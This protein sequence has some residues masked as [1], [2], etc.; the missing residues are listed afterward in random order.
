MPARVSS[1]FLLLILLSAASATAADESLRLRALI[2]QAEDERD[3]D[4]AV[5]RETLEHPDP[6]MR[7]RALRALGRIGDARLASAV[8]RRLADPANVVRREAAFALGEIESPEAFDSL[9]RA[10]MTADPVLVGLAAEALAKIAWDDDAQRR[11]AGGRV[12]AALL[13]A[14]PASPGA[15]PE[16]RRRAL[17]T[18]WR[19]GSETPGLVEGLLELA[20]RPELLRVDESEAL[21]YC[22]SRLGDERLRELLKRAAGDPGT[23]FTRSHAARGL[24]ALAAADAREG[25]EPDLETRE[26]LIGLARLAEPLHS[27]SLED[28]GAEGLLVT[29]G[30]PSPAGVQVNALRALGAFPAPEDPEQALSPLRP[31]FSGTDPSVKLEAIALASRWSVA[32][33]RPFLEG[34]IT[35]TGQPDLQADALV[36]LAAIE[37]RAALPAVQ[38][39]AAS[40]DWRLRAAAAQAL[41]GELRLAADGPGGRVLDGLLLDEDA[42]VVAQAVSVAAGSG[43]RDAAVLVL[44]Q[45]DSRDPVVRALAAAGL[46]QLVGEPFGA[47]E[48]EAAMRAL[49]RV[50]DES[51]DDSARAAS[52]EIL[53]TLLGPDGRSALEAARDEGRLDAETVTPLVLRRTSRLVLTKQ[54]AA[55]ILRAVLEDAAGEV[56]ADARLVALDTLVE[57][58]GDEAAPDLAA[59]FRDPDFTVR[60]AAARLAGQL[61][62]KALART[63]TG[64]VRTGRSHE[65]YLDAARQER[66]GEPVG[67]HLVTERGVV[68]LELL[69]AE[70]VLTVRRLLGLAREGYF[71]GLSFHR[72]VPDFVVQGGDPRG[73]GWG[74][75][76]ESMRCEINK[77]RYDR[78]AVGMA[79]SGKDTGGSQFF[80]T[81]SP[82]PHL[83]G[84]YT[85][86]GRVRPESM[87]VVD[88][89]RRH[90]R[91]LAAVT[92]DQLAEAGGDS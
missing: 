20:A 14:D 18:A 3:A 42:R 65:D 47:D 34:L 60:L 43:R 90:D 62:L 1:T 44:A 75:P 39:F 83:D 31:A 22:A 77:L 91:I 6:Q 85:I 49:A 80:F 66:E 9:R 50:T 71:D 33:A 79:L 17:L 59:A 29:L 81:L 51:L 69:P 13:R 89:L 58:T 35:L 32:G 55:E 15:A 2:L 92:D 84:G 53:A 21:V 74:G 46:P 82:Q 8:A 37:G 72:V 68:D 67:L 26:L 78:G 70:A 7:A 61:G 76:K 41:G 40:P 27:V 25:R 5:L 10:L 12:A 28:Q 4:A 52:F 45:L 19:F 73:D 86:F 56:A 24:G 54:E 57:L 88:R 63:P 87:E 36:A 30:R 48:S 38:R 64:P 11:L 16:S 23:A